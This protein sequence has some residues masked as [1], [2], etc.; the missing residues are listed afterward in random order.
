[1]RSCRLPDQSKERGGRVEGEAGVNGFRY[2]RLETLGQT[3]EALERYPDSGVIAG[4]TDVMIQ[5][6]LGKRE[7]RRLIDLLIPELTGIEEREDG[8]SIG[9]STSLMAVADHFRNQPRPWDI[10]CRSASVGACQT[11]SLATI[12]GNLCTGNASADMATA[13]LVLDTVLEL[14]S[15]R[16]TRL[17]P[18]DRFFIRNRQTA[19]EPGEIVTG[20]FIPKRREASAGAA[21]EKIGKRRGHVIAV[22]NTAAMLARDGEGNIVTVRLAAGTLAPRPMRLYESEKMF[23]QCLRRGEDLEGALA[24]A[25]ETMLTEIQPRDSLRASAEYRRRVA[26]VALARAVRAAWDGKE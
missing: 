15:A 16:A 2:M 5:L 3:L 21:F 4:G 7:D 26:P 20:M 6:R 24:A 13:L 25:G 8:F 18:L 14:R 12:G 23:L 22:L 17:V 1:M 9:P 19:L 10:L 11:R